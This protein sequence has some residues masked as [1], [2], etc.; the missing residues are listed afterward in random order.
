MNTHDM[1]GNKKRSSRTLITPEMIRRIQD[2]DVSE[3]TAE[4]IAKSVGV[5]LSAAHRHVANG[6]VPLKVAVPKKLVD[7]VRL[8]D[9][10]DKDMI[11]RL[12]HKAIRSAWG[13][14]QA[15]YEFGEG[16]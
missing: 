2:L 12:L 10:V 3:F 7:Q 4:E 8:K 1:D 11:L 5:S 6:R 13:D 16:K 15:K 9:E 14:D